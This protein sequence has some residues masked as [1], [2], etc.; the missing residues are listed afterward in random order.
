MLL[1]RLRDAHFSL[2]GKF[3]IDVYGNDNKIIIHA[4]E[5]NDLTT[6]AHIFPVNKILYVSSYERE[7]SQD[8]PIYKFC[9]ALRYLN[10]ENEE[11]EFVFYSDIPEDV[12]YLV[13]VITHYL[14]GVAQ[15]YVIPRLKEVGEA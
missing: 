13:D 10:H 11:Q 9:F 3:E 8:Y 5:E 15:E 6:S 14:A 1:L 2:E 4:V 7:D 12:G